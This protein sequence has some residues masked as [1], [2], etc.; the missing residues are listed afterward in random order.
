MGFIRNK[1][2]RGAKNKLKKKTRVVK[3]LARKVKGFGELVFSKEF[4]VYVRKF[5][6]VGNNNLS[7]GIDVTKDKLEIYDSGS[8]NE[9]YFK[10]LYLQKFGKKLT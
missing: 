8:L 10:Y 4:A 6:Y 1:Y 2:T 5:P 9:G 3:G 7:F